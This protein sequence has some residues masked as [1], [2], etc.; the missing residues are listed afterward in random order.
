MSH[1]ACKIAVVTGGDSAIGREIARALAAD[2]ARVAVVARSA[3]GC[4]KT[5]EEINAG[6]A[7]AATG[8]AVDVAD[9]AAVHD[10][11]RRIG[12]ELGP[13]SIL[14]YQAEETCGSSRVSMAEEDLD[15][16]NP[17]SHLKGAFNTVKA[18][19]RML[20]KAQDPR[21]INLTSVIGLMGHDRLTHDCA[22][23]TGLIAFTKAI[24]RELSGRGV[25]CNAVVPGCINTDM[26]GQL[27]QAVK[28]AV[29]T[30]IPLGKFC[31]PR[32]IA[33][34]VAFLASPAAHYI[35]GQIIAVDGGMTL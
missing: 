29:L 10:L 9:H 20:M 35:T 27:P 22:S 8:Y 26:S 4:E 31:E 13:V 24:A 5:A 16:G 3:A 17:G 28:D 32:D 34:L 12:E 6:F 33:A 15:P 11:V 7:G 2:G 23:K 30:R 21:I 19:M 18:C 25:T 14:V 1:H